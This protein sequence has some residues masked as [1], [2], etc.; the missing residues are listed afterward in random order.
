MEILY[1]PF[2]FKNVIILKF[3]FFNFNKHLKNYKEN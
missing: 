1:E 2:S 3:R